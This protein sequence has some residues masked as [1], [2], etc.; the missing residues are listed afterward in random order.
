MLCPISLAILESGREGEVL[1]D[2]AS[3]SARFLIPTCSAEDFTHVR[4]SMWFPGRYF[5]KS[6]NISVKGDSGMEIWRRLS[7]SGTCGAE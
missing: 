4:N 5:R 6:F 7:L 2:S 3:S 1:A